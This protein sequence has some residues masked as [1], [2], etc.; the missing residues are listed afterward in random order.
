MRRTT[1]SSDMAILLDLRPACP[2]RPS[3]PRV[4]RHAI[5]GS[6]VADDPV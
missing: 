5:A 3:K 1:I 6:M 2:E 4:E